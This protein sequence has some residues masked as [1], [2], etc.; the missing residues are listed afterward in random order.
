[1]IAKMVIGVAYNDIER[2]TTIQL[3]KIFLYIATM[4][5]YKIYDIGIAITGRSVVAVRQAK[6]R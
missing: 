5:N 3:F 1:M 6:Q 2:D 4:L